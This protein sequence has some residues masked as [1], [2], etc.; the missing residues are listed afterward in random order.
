M[1]WTEHQNRRYDLLQT[2]LDKAKDI[3]KEYQMFHVFFRTELKPLNEAYEHLLKQ[4]F[5][6]R[7]KIIKSK[8]QS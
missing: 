6:K 4:P 7:L 2:E 1:N 3:I 8:Q 5:E